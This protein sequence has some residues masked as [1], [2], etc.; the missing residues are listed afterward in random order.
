MP[1]FINP[2]SYTVTIRDLNL[3]MQPGQSQEVSTAQASA[4]WDLG[5]A[6]EQGQLTFGIGSD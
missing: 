5:Q 1:T 3:V 6:L 2:T 4:S